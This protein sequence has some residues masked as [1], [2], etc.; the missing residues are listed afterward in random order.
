MEKYSAHEIFG[1]DTTVISVDKQITFARKLRSCYVA[2]YD[3]SNIWPRRKSKKC[4]LPLTEKVMAYFMKSA[5]N[6]GNKLGRV[7]V[8]V[9]PGY[10]KERKN[11]LHFWHRTAFSRAKSECVC[12]IEELADKPHWR[13]G[14]G[15]YTTSAYSWVTPDFVSDR[16]MSKSWRYQEGS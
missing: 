9:V 3:C 7:T 14:A 11:Q 10:L 16:S 2:V 5:R 13:P 15:K 1:S 8:R 6:W 4:D 12:K